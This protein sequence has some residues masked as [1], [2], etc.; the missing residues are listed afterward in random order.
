MTAMSLDDLR[1]V[2]Q[3][4][5]DAA[6]AITVTAAT[7]TRAG[8]TPRD[9]LDLLIR[10][11]LV[12]GTTDLTVAF[13][14]QIPAPAADSLTVTGS[15]TLLGATDAAVTVTFLAAENGPADV[16]VAIALPTTWTLGTAFP[17]LGRAPFDGLALAD[18]WYVLTTAPQDGFTWNGGVHQLIQGAQLLSLVTLGGPLAVVAALLG[19][20]PGPA[21]LTGAV[22]PSQ[23]GGT[24]ALNL[25]APLAGAVTVPGFALS[26]PRIEL[27]TAPVSD[28]RA[29]LGT[30][31]AFVTTLDVDNAP[32]CD[33]KAIISSGGG[34]LTFAMEA[35]GGTPGRTLD[36]ATV[37]ALVHTDY[38]VPP[39]L[40]A[41]FHEVTLRGLSATISTGASPDLVGVSA[42]IGSS[43]PWQWGQFTLDDVS[44][45][46]SAMAPIPGGPVRILFTATVSLFPEVFGAGNT[47]TVEAVKDVTSGDLVVSAGFAGDIALS[48]LVSGLSQGRLSL[49]SGFDLRFEEF[50]IQLNKPESGAST[51]FLYGMAS[52]SLAIPVVGAQLDSDV[53][54]TV[55]SATDSYQ[56]VGSLLL[57]GNAF[58]VTVTI[59][60][61]E[62]AVTGSWQASGP[63]EYFGIDLLA[64]AFGVTAPPVPPAL[65]LGLK[66]A[67]LSYDFTDKMLA[68]EAESVTYGKAAFVAGHDAAGGASFV[69]GLLPSVAVTLD[70]STI[71]VIGKLVPSGDDIISLSGLRIVATSPTLPAN[72]LPPDAQ[73]VIGPVA[74]S[75]LMMSAELRAG[76]ASD[77][78]TVQFTHDTA[79]TTPAAAPQAGVAPAPQATWINVQRAFGPVQFE[80]IGFTI[81]PETELAILFD[82]SVS[83]G[84]L[85]IGL[86]GLQA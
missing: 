45:E 86:T 73:Q 10:S 84:G 29:G 80:R 53:Q 3:A 39:E 43:G 27:A 38:Q 75:G 42:S 25:T 11:R 5:A 24:P 44:L 23:T 30:W 2:L 85:T 57:A 40:Q 28:P 67:E 63:A 20:P 59:A 26:A 72:P 46:L 37:A 78:V 64:K 15:A 74:T 56:L 60:G 6:H 68:L 49:P 8:L 17:T 50:G 51:Y 19:T 47:F 18:I 7:L 62:T 70:L 58:G 13:T 65:D 16:R 12:L 9:G 4:Q 52:A 83:L 71:D 69:F 61:Q 36:P 48:A 79:D 77:T 22:E 41:L 54:V 82:A 21:P 33:F 35:T 66:S 32:L 1:A 31:L 14:G 76:S 55:D 34:F 81:T